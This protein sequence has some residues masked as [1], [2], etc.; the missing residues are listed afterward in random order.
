[1]KMS[2]QILD[3][4]NV[5]I[6]VTLVM[7]LREWQDM[8]TA[9]VHQMGSI[10]HVNRQPLFKLGNSINS[11]MRRVREEVIADTEMME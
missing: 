11:M 9:L 5:R 10:D 4:D 8:G 1:M 6:E 2:A 3:R 7:T